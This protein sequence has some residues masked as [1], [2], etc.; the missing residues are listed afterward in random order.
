[1]IHAHE[2]IEQRIMNNLDRI[3]ILYLSYCMRFFAI[4]LWDIKKAFEIL[5]YEDHCTKNLQGIGHKVEK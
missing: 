2:W 5:H 3:D 1:M 4:V